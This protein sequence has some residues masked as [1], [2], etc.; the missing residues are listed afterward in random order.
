MEDHIH[1]D[2]ILVIR[3]ELTSIDGDLPSTPPSDAVEIPQAEKDDLPDEVIL[4]PHDTAPAELDFQRANG[5]RECIDAVQQA[6]KETRLIDAADN[7]DPENLSNAES[8]KIGFLTGMVARSA[9]PEGPNDAELLEDALLMNMLGVIASSKLQIRSQ[10]KDE[11]DFTQEQK[12]R[13][14][15]EMYKSKPV[16]FLERFRKVLKEEHLACFDHLA[17]NYEV[18]FYC[19][20]VRKSSLKKVHRTRVRNKR[21]AALQELIKGGDYFSDE[22]MR[23]RDP[24]MYEH[25]VGQ[26]LTEEEIL[27]IN[28]KE[29]A[30]ANC[31]SE[32]MM[33]S[34]DEQILQRRLHR[35]QEQEDA[36][37]EEEEE[38]SEEE[39]THPEDEDWV[40]DGDEKAMLREEFV[41]RM[42]QCFL[43]G[44][45]RDFDYSAVDDNPDFDNLEIVTRDEEERYFDDEEPA[46]IDEMEADE[47]K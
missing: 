8:D 44:K 11:P 18:D 4:Q 25:Y 39:S 20:E 23:L 34:F 29:M 37:M 7:V 12:L 14:L 10:Q 40:P 30:E 6:L 3:A 24:L 19:Q 13:I 41:S 16:V 42:H 46:D 36:C 21:Y 33:N 32:V 9:S 17:G 15:L 31:L 38:D 2:E 26:Y 45:D 28:S 5:E 22:Q 35:Q 47:M 1:D 43:D 27:F